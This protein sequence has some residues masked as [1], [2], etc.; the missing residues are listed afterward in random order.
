MLAAAWGSPLIVDGKVYIGDED[1][2]LAIFNHSKDPKVA[3]KDD[4]GEMK[5]G[6]GEIHMQS[7]VYSTPVVANNVLFIA[8]RS[9]LYAISPGGK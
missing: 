6:V 3:L 9:T 7:S 8:N 1:G 5:P 2:D 4:N